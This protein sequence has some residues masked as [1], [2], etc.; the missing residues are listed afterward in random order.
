MMGRGVEAALALPPPNDHAGA[1]DGGAQQAHP[2][3]WR[4]VVAF[5]VGASELSVRGEQHVQP[6]PWTSGGFLRAP[7]RDAN[8][9]AA[10]PGRRAVREIVD[11][12]SMKVACVDVRYV[13]PNSS[14][15]VLGPV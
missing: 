6:R 3:P 9:K 15:N 1:P 7:A 11:G 5:F 14:V 12:E 4:P 2:E 8:A 13:F 10:A